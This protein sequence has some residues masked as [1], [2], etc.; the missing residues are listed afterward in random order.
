VPTEPKGSVSSN[1]IP[2]SSNSARSSW[3]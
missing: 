2:P 3:T 1:R